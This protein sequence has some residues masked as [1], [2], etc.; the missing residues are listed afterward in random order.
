[1]LL[2]VWGPREGAVEIELSFRRTQFLP[3]DFPGGP[4]VKSLPANEGDTGLS[5]VW[6][7]S[8]CSGVTKIHVPQLLSSPS[9][10]H[11]LQLRRPCAL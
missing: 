10:A 11:K 6:K 2:N 9:R 7:D 8:T 1:M 3:W 4:V 5:L